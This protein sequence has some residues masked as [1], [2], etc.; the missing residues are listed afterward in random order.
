MI[1]SPYSK[2]SIL[3]PAE[4]PRLCFRE[5][6]RARLMTNLHHPENKRALELWQRT[7]RRDFRNYYDDI[8][9][10]H[11]NRLVCYMIESKAFE[12]Y[13]EQDEQ[14]ARALIEVVLTALRNFKSDFTNVMPSRYGGH[15]I[16]VSSCAYDWLYRFWKKEERTEFIAVCERV[17]SE[18]LELGYPPLH[19]GSCSVFGSHDLEQQLQRDVISFAIAVFDERPDIYNAV[20]GKLFDDLIPSVEK[21]CQGGYHILGP[22]YGAFFQCANMWCDLLFFTMCGQHVYSDRLIALTDSFYYLTRSDGENLRIG[23]DCNDDKQGGISIRYPFAVANFLTGAVTG[24]EQ[25][26]RDFFENNHDELMLPSTHNH[27]FYQYGICG[28]GLYTPVVH[29]MFNRLVEPFE[30][31]PYPKARYFPYPNAVTIYKDPARGTTVYMKIGELCGGNHDH[32]DTGNFQIYQN[33]ILASSSGAYWWY[34]NN[35]WYNYDTRTSSHNCLTVRDPAVEVL[36]TVSSWEMTDWT[37]RKIPLLNDGGTRRPA[38]SRHGLTVAE[39]NAE[40]ESNFR[41]AR[42]LSHTESEEKVEIVGDLTEAY[43]HTCELVTRQMTFLPH[44][45]ECGVFT[46]SDRVVAKSE[47]FIKRFHI[48]TMS[49]PVIEGNTFRIEHKGGVLEGTVIE[50]A[51]AKIFALG[52]GEMRFTLNDQPIPCEKPDN[53]E[54]G[55]GKIIIEPADRA[56]E[57]RFVVRMEIKEAKL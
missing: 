53:R 43:S 48:H 2:P 4:H 42:V 22:S 56:K 8:K 57:H 26:R 45:G 5:K 21:W 52:G 35:F 6:D 55:W 47:D 46:V 32:F 44:E 3:P 50:P 40:W 30:P 25:Y 24:N 27:A 11:Y 13:L 16:F 34:G 29:L 37:E 17:M 1:T 20:G 36:E 38:L 49:E 28:E 18:C 41:M 12:A 39:K 15:L 51:N 10:G 54:S 33:G 19:R 7:C 14:K 31:A 9:S 23:D